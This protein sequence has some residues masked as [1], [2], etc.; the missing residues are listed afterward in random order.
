MTGIPFY[1]MFIRIFER[2]GSEIP[3]DSKH[4]SMS[5]KMRF[6]LVISLTLFAM[7]ALQTL[8]VKYFI[9]PESVS[10]YASRDLIQ[11]I[12]PINAAGVIF[13]IINILLL[14]TGINKRINDSSGLAVKL[15]D[16]NL[17]SA[18]L[19][20]DSRDELGSLKN[21]LNLVKNNTMTLVKGITLQFSSHLDI[22][23]RLNSLSNVNSDSVE[24]ITGSI[25][26]VKNQ[27][28]MLNNSVINTVNSSRSLSDQ[29]GNVYNRITEQGNLIK[30]TS[31]TTNIILSSLNT[32]SNTSREKILKAK[33]LIDVSERESRNLSE[34][35]S[36]IREIN[37]NI[38]K[39][40]EMLAKISDI[41]D[42]TNMLAM[43]AAIEAAHAGNAGKGFGVVAE[44]IRKLADSTAKSSSEISE[45]IA[46]ITG[47]VSR[48]SGIGAETAKNY[49]AIHQDII[50]VIESFSGI[51]EMVKQINE[52][53]KELFALSDELH[54]ISSSVSDSTGDMRIKI[55]EV[56]KV[57]PVLKKI[58]EETMT[59][60]TF[61][62]NAADTISESSAELNRL[63][64]ELKH[65]SR[66]MEEE[67]NRFTC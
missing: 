25:A 21:S 23:N 52:D 55:E 19:D 41:S 18:D 30:K 31:N 45:S 29:V 5:I 14:F 56:D 42:R 50:S 36:Y 39:I 67:I 48:V 20:I 43:N 32:I 10:I 27:I 47:T 63:T 62:E 64:D 40:Y 57:M 44:E 54:S 59:A 35:V 58:S 37:V 51:E 34:T 1:I 11:R 15:A 24:K 12:L 28:E 65:S 46:E 8:S 26:R 49:Q 7:I 60:A 33:E 17:T 2:A 3:F 38:K 61:A 16:G 9:M 22:N 53:G 6:T 4:M 66:L 13:T